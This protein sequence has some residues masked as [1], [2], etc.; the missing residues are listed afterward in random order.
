MPVVTRDRVYADATAIIG[1]GR[2]DRLDLLSLLAN[3]I[4]L[5][6]RIWNEVT[7][8]PDK[9]GVAAILRARSAGLLAVV[10]EGDPRAFPQLDSG[11]STVLTAAAAAHASVI[12]DERKARA[13]LKTDPLLSRQ[14]PRAIGTLG[15]IL[16]AK[17]GGRVAEVR[18]LLDALTHQDFWISPVLYRDLLRLAGEG[19]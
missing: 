1:L 10:E 13:L 7:V 4:H 11:E 14:I 6:T 3:P 17:R 12:V 16:L 18:P 9:P 8:D 19:D 5:T 15:L 2:I